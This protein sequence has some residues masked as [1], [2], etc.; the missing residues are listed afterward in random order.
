MFAKIMA[1]LR[2][3]DE[4]NSVCEENEDETEDVH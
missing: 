2:E 4:R 1:I 3:G